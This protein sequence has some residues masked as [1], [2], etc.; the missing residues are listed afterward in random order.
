MTKRGFTLTEL[1]I[2]MS[3]LAV[4]AAC[5]L[6]F[7]TAMANFSK[8]SS[9]A[10][11]RAKQAQDIRIE[12]DRW[13][14]VVDQEG[15]TVEFNLG[16]TLL[17]ATHGDWSYTVKRIETDE[18]SGGKLQFIYPESVSYE[19]LIGETVVEIDVS[20]IKSIYFAQQG[21]ESEFPDPFS[22]GEE[23]TFPIEM[24]LSPAEFLCKIVYY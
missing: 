12:L 17:R 19:K 3:L 22:E 21:V 10:L 2:A 16:N 23:Q 6:L 14:S 18:E 13:F 20:D 24:H 1:I 7:I 9:L 4:L 11:R 8:N 15:V 5:V